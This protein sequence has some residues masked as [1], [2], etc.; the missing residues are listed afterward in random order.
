MRRAVACSAVLSTALVLGQATVALAQDD[1]IPETASDRIAA[2]TGAMLRGLDRMA[3]TSTDLQLAQGEMAHIGHLIVRLQECRYQVENP[4][5]EAY[6]WIEIY[7][8]RAS[9]I[10]FAGWM[11]ASSPALNALDHAR[12]DLWV[13]NCTTS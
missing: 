2:G 4:A 7:D 10:L 5:G 12:Y 11:I 1:L 8:T 13:L 3:G 6:A 9:D